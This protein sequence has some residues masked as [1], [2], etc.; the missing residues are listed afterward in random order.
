LPAVGECAESPEGPGTDGYKPLMRNRAP[1]YAA[2]ANAMIAGN[3]FALTT[4]GAVPPTPADDGSPAGVFI[5]MRKL[6][7]RL[8]G[9]ARNRRGKRLHRW[10]AL[11]RSVV[12][13]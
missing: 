8:F 4:H 10:L 11:N 2:S 13:I 9:P 6:L 1:M 3:T 12:Q 7:I 5:F